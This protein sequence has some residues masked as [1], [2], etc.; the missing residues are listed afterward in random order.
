MTQKR[1]KR[2]FGVPLADFLAGSWQSEAVRA[3]SSPLLTEMGMITP[4]GKTVLLNRSDK[5][6]MD[7]KWSFIVLANFLESRE[8]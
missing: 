4:K 5:E 3:L 2:G 6:A 7:L 1:R 8:I